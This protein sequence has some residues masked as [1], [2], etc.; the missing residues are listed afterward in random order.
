MTPLERVVAALHA[1]DPELDATAV[2]ESLWLAAR[3]GPATPP[4]VGTDHGAPA[5]APGTEVPGTP[6]HRAAP[7]SAPL[8][9]PESGAPTAPLHERLP[10]SDSLVRGDVSSIPRAGALPRALEVSRALRPWKRLWRTGRRNVLD[11]GATVDGY[12]R[13]GELLPVFSAAPERWF[14]LVLVVDRSPSMQVW[15]ETV[16]A[17]T[18]T[19]DRLGAFRTLQVRDLT[20]GTDS[21]IRL[22]D[23]QGRSSTAG[24]LRSPNGR[25]LVLT[26]SDCSADAW[27]APE[28]WRQLRA[29]A[30]TTPVALLNP[31]PTKLWRRGGLDLPTVRVTP[32]PPGADSS[33]LSFRLPLLLPEADRDGADGGWLP[34]P[35]VSLSPHQ[36]DRWSRTVVLAAPEGCAA[37]LVPPGGRMPG[38]HVQ[39]RPAASRGPA[40][41]AE[42][43]LRTA[44]PAAARLAVLCS[45]FDR[46]SLGLLHTIR[47]ELVPRATTADLAEVLTSGVFTWE[48]DVDGSAQVVVPQQAQARLRQDLTEHEVWRLNR[49]LSRSVSLQSG[50]RGRLPAVVQHR[51]GQQEVSAASVP[52]GQALER[53]RELLGL[54]ATSSTGAADTPADATPGDR[55]GLAGFAVRL[56]LAMLPPGARSSSDELAAVVDLVAAELGVY[57][58]LDRTELL[59]QLE[60]L[61]TIH[62]EPVPGPPD[63]TAHIPWAGRRTEG[64]SQGFWERYLRYLQESRSARTDWVR[65]LDEST[66]DVLGRLEDPRRPGNWRRTGLVMTHPGSGGTSHG[67]GL[68]AKAIDA[69]YRLIV[70]LSGTTNVI[71]AQTQRRVDEGLLGFDTGFQRSDRDGAAEFRIGAGALAHAEHLSILSLTSSTMGGDFAGVDAARL[72]PS[73]GTIPIVLVIKRNRR[74]IDSLRDWLTHTRGTPDP[75]TGELVVRG[76]PLLVIDGGGMSYDYLPKRRA[77]VPLVA[78]S[79]VYKLVSSFE[80][81]ALVAYPSTPYEPAL[82]HRF[83]DTFAC[84]FSTSPQS[85]DLEAQLRLF[86][87]QGD[88]PT[89]TGADPTALVQLVTDHERWLPNR[90]TAN[91]VPAAELP[92]SL[93]EAINAFVLVCAAR[94]AR[95]WPRLYNSMS[96]SVSRFT[97][98]Q[99]LVRE[100]VTARLDFIASALRDHRTQGAAQLTTYLRAMWLSVFAQTETSWSEVA[101]HLAAEAARIRVV[102]LNSASD[103]RLDYHLGVLSVVV[104]GGTKLAQ[105]PAP[106][107]LAIS[108]NLLPHNMRRALV[109]RAL[110]GDQ[111]LCRHYTTMDAANSYSSTRSSADAPVRQARQPTGSEP[112]AVRTPQDFAG[113]RVDTLRF[114]LLP[115]VLQ[116]NLRTLEDFVRSLD[117]IGHHTAEPTNGSVMWR[118]VPHELVLSRFFDTYLPGAESTLVPAERV[119]AYIRRR[120]PRGELLAWN[121]QLISK[122]AASHEHDIAGHRIG[123]VTR[124]AVDPPAA[125]ASYRVNALMNPRD[126]S[127]DLDQQQYLDALRMTRE[128]AEYRGAV[129]VPEV[130]AGPAVRAVRR[131]DQ[132]LLTIYLLESPIPE[133]DAPG[134]P[135]VGFAVS[136][137]FGDGPEAGG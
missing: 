95:N 21:T 67:I 73:L 75:V 69:G 84:R 89:R 91:S 93:L 60:T 7:P 132:P 12:A 119:A 112:P 34:L 16:D 45:Q 59:R 64:R 48:T 71:R 81:A 39:V 35:V 104:V 51:N 11:V 44:A 38:R 115:A 102:A 105:G 27:R 46:L 20:F 113:S 83:P 136:F 37:V 103:D 88:E 116:Q 36:L 137:P 82:F 43:F 96:I 79:S 107:G 92:P 127:R 47:E 8:P 97:R 111:E 30:R 54:P 121:V 1:A 78:E 9:V 74:I 85:P 100:Q 14:D 66:D 22:R 109:F 77:N 129:S 62:Q 50:G 110:Q 19:L 87:S 4:P 3:L 40:E 42:G 80:K 61:V 135:V 106:E 123:L 120:V 114:S 33:Q 98:V 31:L 125:A 18:G 56:A 126:E 32:G 28:V 26:V 72:N 63:I 25:R 24:Q 108:Y 53:T 10:G 124:R 101:E 55:V 134:T 122:A 5:D 94:R 23:P 17:L 52:F 13:S 131:P 49:V 65:S 70:F 41:R 6:E 68:A 76:L 128:N 58:R 90:H 130:P 133:A 15:G 57:G 118:G 29:W 2:A 99:A 86:A 117:E